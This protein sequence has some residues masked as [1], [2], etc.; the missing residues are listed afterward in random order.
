M[1]VAHV[2]H[3]RP[4]GVDRN[5]ISVSTFSPNSPPIPDKRSNTLGSYF[6]GTQ[7][8]AQRTCCSAG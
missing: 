1:V 8:E 3:V 6:I 5:S 4:M 2:P 7:T